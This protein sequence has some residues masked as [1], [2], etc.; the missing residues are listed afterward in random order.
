V[1]S[2]KRKKKPAKKPPPK[3]RKAKR[4]PVQRKDGRPTKASIE[5]EEGSKS[6]AALRY[7]AGRYYATDADNMC[8]LLELSKLPMYSMVSL[9]ALTRW[10]ADDGW[11]ERRRQFIENLNKKYESKLGTALVQ[12]RLN[13][14]KKTEDVIDRVFKTLV[15]KA[16]D[17]VLEANSLEGAANAY[18]RLCVVLDDQREKLADAVMPEPIA[19]QQQ[20]QLPAVRPR[21]SME[22]S[23]AAALTIV[24]M[25]REETRAAL[26][27]EE[28]EKS[29]EEEKPHMRVIEGE[30]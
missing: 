20:A 13:Q 19:V 1:P 29:E 12:A 17:Q 14:L 5:F 16:K 3:P 26:R 8:S 15:T 18:A 6:Y 25:R 4:T 11:V 22:E 28:A 30:K 7:S 27:A 24:R 9:S 23:R 2:K 10:C 21:L